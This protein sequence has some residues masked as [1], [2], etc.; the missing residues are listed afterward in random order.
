MSTGFLRTGT[1]RVSESTPMIRSPAAVMTT[2]GRLLQRVSVRS[3]AQPHERLESD[4]RSGERAG[5]GLGFEDSQGHVHVITLQRPPFERQPGDHCLCE[6]PVNAQG[7]IVPRVVGEN[8]ERQLRRAW[9][10]GS[11]IEPFRSVVP[12]VTSRIERFAIDRHTAARA[13]ADAPEN[14]HQNILSPT[15]GPSPR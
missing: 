3:R 1:F 14:A 2:M 4:A 12:K 9:S 10:L 7:H 8:G 5:Q 15:S 11:P 6:L 13:L